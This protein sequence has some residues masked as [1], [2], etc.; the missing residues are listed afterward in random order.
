MATGGKEL[1]LYEESN[2]IKCTTCSKKSRIKQAKSYC[3]NCTKY[4]CVDCVDTHNEYI[5]D[6]T[7]VGVHDV[8]QLDNMLTEKCGKHKDKVIELFCA[9][10][11]VVVC[12][13][14]ATLKHR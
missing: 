12:S 7:L 5:E 9:D 14:C 2:D 10:H 11:D 4:L 6:H 8:D 3:R 13:D 1:T